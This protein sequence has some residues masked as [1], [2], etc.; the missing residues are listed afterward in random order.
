LNSI[1]LD[2]LIV[3]VKNPITING[4]RRKGTKVGEHLFVLETP[5]GSRTYAIYKLH[6]K[7]RLSNAVLLRN[8]AIELAKNYEKIYSGY[9]DI[10]NSYPD[11]VLHQVLRYTIP[12]GI[13]M[14]E[15]FEN[16]L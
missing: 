6:D 11:M 7:K 5:I 8:A 9:F 2:V 4:M 14:Y 1:T 16:L 12:N 13:A 3:V 10:W 15:Y